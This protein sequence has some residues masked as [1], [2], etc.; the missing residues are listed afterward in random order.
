MLLTKTLTLPFERV[1][2]DVVGPLAV[3]YS[4]NRYILTC[5]DELTKYMSCVAMPDVEAETT[6]NISM[7]K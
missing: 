2:I 7:M 3:I 6:A 5:Q 4:G 1:Y